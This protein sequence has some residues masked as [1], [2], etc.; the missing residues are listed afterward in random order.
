MPAI[1]VASTTSPLS[2]T[3]MLGDGALVMPTT[4]TINP[5]CTLTYAFEGSLFAVISTSLSDADGT[6][7]LDDS[8]NAVTSYVS[9]TPYD[10][11]VTPSTPAGVAMDGIVDYDRQ[12]TIL[13]TISDPCEDPLINTAAD[14]PDMIVHAQGGAT[15][16]TVLTSHWSGVMARCW[17]GFSWTTNI[18]DFSDMSSTTWDGAT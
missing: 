6:L 12:I 1:E 17:A 9:A 5:T 10:V 11:I 15:L 8:T 16:D 3:F 14:D 13:I 18:G 4:W 7:T 2:Y